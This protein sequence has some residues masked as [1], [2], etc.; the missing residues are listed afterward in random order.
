MSQYTGKHG[1]C[2]A[3]FSSSPINFNKENKLPKVL[4]KSTLESITPKKN[5]S[6]R[7][8]NNENN[9]RPLTNS[10][11]STSMT[12]LQKVELKLSRKSMSDEKLKTPSSKQKISSSRLSNDKT[13]VTHFCSTT[14]NKN[15]IKKTT[16]G[17]TTTTTTS[18]NIG[19]SFRTPKR[20]FSDHITAQSTPECFGNVQIETPRGKSDHGVDE[21]TICE[22][23]SSNLTVGIRVRPM[24]LKEL[25]EPKVI[26]IVKVEGQNVIVDC[27][28][29]QHTFSYDHCFI[30]RADCYSPRHS[31]QD[32]VFKTLVLPLVN[33]AF[34]GYNVCLFA[35]GQ[36]GSGKSYSMMG[37]DTNQTSLTNLSSDAGIIPRFCHEIFTR[38]SKNHDITTTIDISYF[39]IYNEKIHDLLGNTSNNTTTN[40]NNKRAPLK[41]REHPV[42][43]PYVVDLSQ[44]SIKN[45]D[46][47]QT[48]AATGMNEKSSRSHSIFS[49]IL[50][51]SKKQEHTGKTNVEISK[52]SKINLVDLAGSE[53][54]SQTCASGDR[55]REGVSINK[56][57]LIL[58][59]VI[60]S[61]AENTSNTK[62]GFVPYRESVLTWLLKESLGGNSKTAMLAT[63]SPSSLHLEETLATLRYACQARSIVNRVRINEDPHDKLIRELKAEVQRLRGVRE[64]YERQ[65]GPRRILD[66]VDLP[67]D[68]SC[69]VKNKQM[70]IEKLRDQLK[71]TEEQLAISQKSRS[72]RLKDAEDNKNTEL[73]LLRRCGIA[74]AIDINKNTDPCLVNLAPDPMLSGTLLYLLPQGIIRIRRQNNKNKDKLI[75]TKDI[76]LDGPL[77]S[78]LHCTIEN[79]NG[80][81]TLTPEGKSETYVNGQ[82]VAEKVYLKNGDRLVIGGNHYF[83]VCN[84]NDPNIPTSLQPV[85]FDFAH[86]EI[87][88][89]QEEKLRA[90]IE[91]SKQKAIKE[92]ENAK[93][94]VE[95]QLGLQKKNYEFEIKKL[96]KTLKQQKETLDAVNKRK[97][98]LEVEKE[99]LSYEIEKNNKTKI[100]DNINDYTD[101]SSVT[102][103]KSNFLLELERILNETTADVESVLTVA[104]SEKAITAGGITLHEMQLLVREATERCRDIGLNYEF[105]QQRQVVDKELVPIIRIRDKDKMQEIFWKP[106]YF[107]DWIHRL[108]DF[109]DEDT[110]KDL[111]NYEDDWEPFESDSTLPEYTLDASRISINLTPV[112]KQLNESIHQLSMNSSF[113]DTSIDKT[114]DSIL[115]KRHEDM[116]ACLLQMEL[117]TKTLGKLCHQ[118]EKPETSCQVT[119]SLD[120]VEILINTLRNVLN[121]K[122]STKNNNNNNNNDHD[123]NKIS[124]LNSKII[125]NSIDDDKKINYRE[126]L[127]EPL[128]TNKKLSS[129]DCPF[130]QESSSAKSVRFNLQ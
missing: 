82:I 92:L 39:E 91:E 17:I 14:K 49:I 115:T 130:F 54:L 90:E 52:R 86:Q 20:F 99:I 113:L 50:T 110:I 30:S 107:L 108:R 78:S 61:L 16:T 118:Y 38:L 68:N 81:L 69:E 28:S 127:Q 37:S 109:D 129:R 122:H 72:E 111:L 123:D 80:C 58:G 41:V 88:A 34:E 121:T 46:D 114:T 21:Q 79:D 51:Q 55:L 56:S 76:L 5:G 93:T 15:S 96:D 25:S 77:V 65:L 19:G 62:R 27:E 45:Y 33:N 74:I 126:K 63:V 53:R 2:N 73:Q 24:S 83:K 23:E 100:N 7:K 117:A 70:E 106:M 120:K 44:H 87:L 105:L 3:I 29:A 12:T 43:G 35:Y 98:E 119:K 101:D 97:H 32:K 8:L 64:G 102:K 125:E 103:Y 40:N 31:S 47:L 18:T 4:P 9:N 67:N 89:I 59:K 57:L 71:R 48:T 124:E 6:T 104:S 66:D 85:D 22:G 116:N 1:Y 11:R 26:P 75:N 13:P 112:K 36:T 60:G 84:P 128:I 95:K 10:D 42:Y 94:E